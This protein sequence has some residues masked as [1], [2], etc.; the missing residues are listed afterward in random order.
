MSEELFKTTTG[1]DYAC[2]ALD[3]Q[4]Y[5]E[6][7]NRL[8]EESGMTVTCDATSAGYETIVKRIERDL[9]DQLIKLQGEH[10]DEDSDDETIARRLDRDL[11]QF[12]TARRFEFPK[13]YG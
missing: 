9:S 5:S 2:S 13:H 7:V 11:E 1:R 3:E 10:G 8:H 6:L 12:T 4:L